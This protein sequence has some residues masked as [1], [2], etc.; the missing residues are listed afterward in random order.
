[1]T[2]HSNYKSINEYSRLHN[3]IESLKFHRKY[4]LSC[5]ER[6]LISIVSFL[7]LKVNDSVQWTLSMLGNTLIPKSRTH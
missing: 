5:E 6:V 2:K 1:M 4:L 7:F 3:S